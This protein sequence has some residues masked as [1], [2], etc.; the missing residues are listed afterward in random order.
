VR[1]VRRKHAADRSCCSQPECSRFH[2]VAAGRRNVAVA[3]GFVVEQIDEI[4]C[5]AGFVAVKQAAHQGT[6]F[7]DR[8]E[9]Q[10]AIVKP[11]GVAV[12]SIVK[13]VADRFRTDVTQHLTLRSNARF[14]E[15]VTQ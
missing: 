9:P 1:R 2:L 5:A 11:A 12:C 3:V 13:Q 15:A 14:T 10:L 6:R 8:A 7:V 4:A